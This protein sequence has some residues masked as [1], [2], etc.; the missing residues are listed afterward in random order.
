[1]AVLFKNFKVFDEK[2]QVLNNYNV[3]VEGKKIVYMAESNDNDAELFAKYEFEKTIDGS[4]KLLMP[5]FYNIHSHLAMS[6]LR[7]YAE[8]MK[9]QEW[10]FDNIFPFEARINAEDIYWGTKLC[11]AESLRFGIV[12]ATDMYMDAVANAEAVKEIG[13]KA[14]LALM[15]ENGK[16]SAPYPFPGAVETLAKY[17]NL[18]DDRVKLDAYIHAEYTTKESFVRQVAEYAKENKLNVHLHLS[19]T[20]TEHEE[21]KERRNGRTPAEYFNDCEVFDNPTTAAHCVWVE[22]KDMEIF[23]EK[24]V[25]VA[26]NPVSN[27]KLASGIAPVKEMMDLGINIGIGTDGVSSNNNLNML[28][29]IKT[30]IMLQKVKTNNPVAV[31]TTE[32]MQAA[33]VNGAKAQGR[34]DSGVI[35]V[36]NR[37]DLVVLDIDKPYMYPQHNLLNNVVYSAMGTDVVLT[38]VDGKI[39]YDNREYLTLDLAET[40]SQVEARRKRILSE[41]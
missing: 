11:I 23:R 13:F 22:P 29:E 3:I 4:G 15:A 34:T 20:Q 40:V 32:V 24:G 33:T 5:G 6:L 38:M 1:M 37:A 39:L 28:E 35:K 7:G 31:T 18:D 8:D 36:G 16:S 12:S 10:L 19:E 25:T 17:H 41:L 21:C 30:L 9:L 26:T 27:L 14:N 2:F